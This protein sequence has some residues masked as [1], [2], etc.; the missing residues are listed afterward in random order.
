MQNYYHSNLKVTSGFQDPT[1]S[2]NKK[3]LPYPP[4]YIRHWFHCS[5]SIIIIIIIVILLKNNIYIYRNNQKLASTQ[6]FTT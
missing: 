4:Y 2:G 5:M 6:L 1:L 3:L